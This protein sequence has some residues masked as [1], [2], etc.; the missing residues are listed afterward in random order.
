MLRRLAAR[1]ASMVELH[2]AATHTAELGGRVKCVVAAPDDMCRTIR[3]Q[4]VRWRWVGRPIG[5]ASKAL[6]NNE[7]RWPTVVTRGD[8]PGSRSFCAL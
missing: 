3:V 5:R 2:S 6:N 4:I 1:D 8:F 7:A